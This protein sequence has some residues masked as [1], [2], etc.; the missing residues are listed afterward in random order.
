L[1]KHKTAL[2]KGE[3][4]ILYDSSQEKFLKEMLLSPAY[5]KLKKSFDAFDQRLQ[6]VEEQLSKLKEEESELKAKFAYELA[7]GYDK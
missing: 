1:C 4:S 7:Q 5:P 3:R 2:V 6:I